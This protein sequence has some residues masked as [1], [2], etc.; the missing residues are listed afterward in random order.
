[1]KHAALGAIAFLALVLTIVPAERA[2][3]ASG[4]RTRVLDRTLRCTVP[5]SAGIRIVYAIGQS[6][7]R[8]Q[9][10][11]SRWFAVAS[12]ALTLD[13]ATFAGVQAGAPRAERGLPQIEAT[14]W[15]NTQSCRPAASSVSLAPRGLRGG[16]LNRIGETYKCT[17]PRSIVLRVRAEFRSPVNI[18]AS[19]GVQSSE[20]PLR[21]GSLAIRTEQGKRLLYADVL[22]S[23]RARLFVAPSCPRT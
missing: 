7:V 1:V 14:F 9:A 2:E 22:E 20:A 23:G 4:A 11:P 8:D 6:G 16:P 3:P 17:M 18:R 19:D 13:D 21:K 15:L 10:D 5:L 12:V